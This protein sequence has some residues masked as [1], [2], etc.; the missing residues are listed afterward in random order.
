MD[1]GLF[2]IVH[3]LNLGGELIHT[4]AERREVALLNLQ[5]G[6]RAKAST[7][8]DTA[9]ELLLAGQR[10]FGAA[11]WSADHAV[12]F[13]LHL[14]LAESLYLCGRFDAAQHGFAELLEKAR[15][16]IDRARVVRLRSV[17]YENMARYSEALANAREGL[18]LFDLVLPEPE[19]DKAAA[20]E[21]E[22]AAIATLRAGRAIATLI[23]LPVMTDPDTRM[24]MSMLTDVWSAAYIVGD[25][26]L[27]RLIS[28]TMV[29]LSLEH[30]NVEES[31]YG[32]VTHAITVGPMRGEYAAAY[33]FGRLALAVNE[34]FGDARRRA[35]IYQQFHAHVNLWCQ[36]LRTCMAYAREA[37][38]SGL[39]SGDHLYAAYGAGTEP[40]AAM[41]A[42]QDLAQFIADYTPSVALIEKLKNTGFADAVRLILNGA[43]ALQGRTQGPLS[44]SD[45]T[46]DEDS[47]LRAYKGNPFFATIH[48]VVRLQLCTLLGTPEQAL[49]AALHSAAL[50]HHVPGTIWP[51]IHTFWH[52]M[53]LAAQIDSGQAAR[54]GPWLAE[55]KQAQA[56]FET[57]AVHCAENFRCQA[58]LLGAEVAR[59]EGRDGE[60]VALGEQAIEF[61][62]DKPLLQYE[63]LAHEWCGRQ[64]LQLGQRSL[65]AIHLHE[66]C[67]RYERWGAFAKAQALRCE[68]PALALALV[69]DTPVRS[70]PAPSPTA[71]DAVNTDSADER[72]HGLDLSSVLKAALAIAGEVE[73]HA[74]VAALM[75]IA[76]ENA[77]AERGA[78]V[79]EGA[80]GARVHAADAT[81]PSVPAAEQ[82]VALEQSASVPLGI[83]NFVRRTAET[84]VLAVAE[85]DEQHGADPY[86]ALH[87]PR[88]VLC[89]PVQRQGQ[90]LGVL[91][92]EHR[93]VS[94]VFTPQRL[95]TVRI[96]AAQ[97]AISLDNARLFAD[98]R[99]EVAEHCQARHDLSGALAEVEQLKDGLEAENTYLRRDLIANVSHDL[100]T[101]LVA[102]RGYLEV[103]AAKGD[104]LSCSQRQQYLGIAVR[105][106]EHLATLIDELFEL[107]KLDFKGM[108]PN[109]EPFPLGELAAD[110][111]HK[112]QLAADAKRI[113]LRVEVPPQL[114]FVDADVSLMERVLDNLIGNALKHTPSGGL[115]SVRLCAQDGRVV[116]Q[117][118][119]TG[120]GIPQAEQAF[121]FDRFYRGTNDRTSG[122]GGAGLGLAIT[123][124][125]LELHD[126][127]I[128]VRSDAQAGTCFAFSLPAHGGR[129]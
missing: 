102:M 66:A 87:R 59:I 20:L 107:A 77:G 73:M 1:S 75:R 24:V 23:D 10:L 98:L 70:A 42:T 126:T 88:S 118:S 82:G 67:Q 99:R 25:P 129:C 65:A 117:V 76:I 12:C 94:G 14:E 41:V 32:Y 119:D 34:R 100:R 50:V 52:G 110:V 83:V 111:V 85:S 95:R 80:A 79:L 22:I 9:L 3:H 55:L 21:R 19:A 124:R 2:D 101:P 90:S 125:I 72:T 127:D 115:V 103:L 51:V 30:G 15:S 91:Y 31:A 16:R 49:Q 38:R 63:A 122:S 84:V 105:Q 57:L 46:L 108:A 97:A 18:A 68:H 112:F 17:Q 36:P 109:R 86:V 71:A 45:T 13:E 5:A 121:I 39:D 92:L 123:K 33:E 6:R 27:A 53:A 96:L 8:H 93:H 11:A 78:L 106:S 44:L 56:Q 113:G 61:A 26:T 128:R 29:R 62:A 43:K 74:L 116:T 40:W 47:Y 4:A 104:S 64:R 120:S 35:K 48:A 28:A 60:A 89:V 37:C 7:A 81:D 58:L 69:P 54:H 114:P